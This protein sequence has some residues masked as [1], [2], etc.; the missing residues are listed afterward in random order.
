MEL[1]DENLVAEC[2]SS[3]RKLLSSAIPGDAMSDFEQ[4]TP[5]KMVEGLLNGIEK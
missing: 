1:N 4:I 5:L 3:I 2:V